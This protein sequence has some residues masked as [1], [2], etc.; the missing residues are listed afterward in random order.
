M[1]IALAGY[2]GFL[3]KMI[4]N[5]LSGHDYILLNRE[6]LYGKPVALESAMEGAHI[7]INM[8]GSPISQRWT[9][10][11]RKKILKSRHGVNTNLVT[12]I[13]GLEKKPGYFIT[14]SAIGIYDSVGIQDENSNSRGKG[15]MSS[16]VQKWEEPVGLLDDRVKHVILR[17]GMVLGRDGGVMNPFRKVMRF[18][19]APVMGSGK[20]MVSFIHM[21]DLTASV[22]FIIENGLEGVFNLTSPH[23]V[24][25]RGFVNALARVTGARL[26]IRI[27]AWV[28]KLV[29]G[30]AHTLLTEGPHVIPSRLTEEGFRFMYPGIDQ[31]IHNLVQEI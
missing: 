26:K 25:H 15:F 9:A 21:G 6:L 19:I 11:N 12:A 27:P 23:P 24:D 1:K 22:G 31:A 7:V 13:N 18:G 17:I 29:M 8:S 28:L 10:A 16:V 30:E 3:G 14:V 5:D 4:M 20:Q 2:N